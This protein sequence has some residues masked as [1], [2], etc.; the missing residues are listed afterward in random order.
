MTIDVPHNARS[1]RTR[2]ALLD[3]ARALIER[4]GFASLTMTAVAEEAGVS[5]RGA[6]MHFASRE[7][8]LAALYRHLGET[9]HLPES[10]DRVW[11]S[12]DAISALDEWA[13]HIARAHPRILA[14]SRAIE[15]ASATDAGVAELHEF[16]MSNWYRSCTRLAEW[17]AADGV[18]A[19]GWSPE[20]AADWM[21]GQMSWDLLERL[22]VDRGWSPETFGDRYATMLRSTLVAQR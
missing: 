8:L 9:E 1:R 15:R 10:R 16:T 14:V 19:D 22:V 17:L 6:Y 2:S 21:W 12:P 4:D 7:D 18:L 11:Q 3:T 13:R 5:R 20:D